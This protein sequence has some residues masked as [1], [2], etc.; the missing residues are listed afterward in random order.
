M[1]TC[2]EDSKESI[3]QLLELISGFSKVAACK[4]KTQKPLVFLFSNNKAA[5]P[6]WMFYRDSQLLRQ[7]NKTTHGS[8]WEELTF[9]LCEPMNKVYLS[10][11][12]CF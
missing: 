10:V 1:I 3:K 2:V 9:E 12:V 8:I 5:V 11:Y 7:G 4:P 6:T